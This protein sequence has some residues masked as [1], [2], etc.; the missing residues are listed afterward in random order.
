MEASIKL[1]LLFLFILSTRFITCCAKEANNETSSNEAQERPLKSV[2]SKQVVAQSSTESQDEAKSRMRFLEMM[3]SLENRENLTYKDVQQQRK[4]IEMEGDII[5]GGIMSIHD[6][7]EDVCG[8]LMPKGSIQELEAI[9]FTI[10]KVNAREN[11]LPGIKLG[12]FIMDDCNR[13]SYSLEQAANFIQG[14]RNGLDKSTDN[15]TEGD[16]AFQP[17]K[18]SGVISSLSSSGTMEVANLLRLFKIP[19]VSISSSN[20]ELNNTQKLEYLLTTVPSNNSQI[21]FILKMILSLNLS[22]VSVLYEDSAYGYQ[23]FM[24]LKKLLQR[25]NISLALSQRLVK[26]SKLSYK[27]YYDKAVKHLVAKYKSRN[28]VLFGSN[29]EVT[30]VMQAVDRNSDAGHFLWITCNKVSDHNLISDINYKNTAAVFTL[31]RVMFP[32]REFEVYFRSLKVE[33]NK[34]NPWFTEYWEQ[35]FSCKFPDSMLTPANIFATKVCDGSEMSTAKEFEIEEEIQYASDSVWAFAYAIKAMHEDLCAGVPG[36]CGMMKPINGTALL[37]YLKKASFD[38]I[39]G[40]NFKFNTNGH[41][42]PQFEILQ[43]KQ[44]TPGKYKWL[45]VDNFKKMALDSLS[46]DFCYRKNEYPESDNVCIVPCGA[47]QVKKYDDIKCCWLCINCQGFQIVE[48]ETT[49]V[50]CPYGYFPIENHTRCKF[51]PY[52]RVHGNP[53]APV[54]AFV[55]AVIFMAGVALMIFV[56]FRDSLDIDESE[57][58]LSPKLLGGFRRNT[59]RDIYPVVLIEKT[60]IQETIS[61]EENDDEPNFVRLV[62]SSN[63]SVILEGNRY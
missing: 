49:C 1:Y 4:T 9:L 18:V 43:A 28:V 61:F 63:Y 38:G 11:F 24:V 19:Q 10:D 35:T 21:D 60:K 27:A 48:N 7:Y 44:E 39:S 13:D 46:E 5:L 33:T 3:N 51:D 58:C 12:A 22:H 6:K 32:V 15:C 42:P 62:K 14:S 56:C 29:K 37:N 57:E 23:S 55:A 16:S 8:P 59:E 40:E 52:I 41:G 54:L 30:G 25:N 36:V 47:G 31:R 50:D 17:S 45:Y 53:Q 2:A 34:R 20:L 26:H